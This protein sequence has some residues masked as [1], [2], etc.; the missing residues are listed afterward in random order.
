MT[1]ET[2]LL[3]L[4]VLYFLVSCALTAPLCRSLDMPRE[5]R[6]QT[7]M[8][9][10]TFARDVRSLAAQFLKPNYAFVEVGHAHLS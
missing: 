6:R 1:D 3:F 8:F 2:C 7:A 9:S 5:D 10:A 4:L